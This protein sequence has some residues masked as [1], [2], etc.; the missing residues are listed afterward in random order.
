MQPPPRKK[1]SNLRPI[2]FV[3]GF[4]MVIG[5][6]AIALAPKEWFESEPPPPQV[7][8]LNEDDPH[9]QIATLEQMLADHPDHSPIALM[10][11]NLYFDDQNFERAVFYYRQFLKTDTSAGGYEA[12]LDLA[13]ALYQMNKGDEA[14]KEIQWILDRYPDHADA[15]YNLG[16]IQANMGKL[17]EAKTTWEKLIAKHPDDTLAIFAKQSLPMLSKPAGHP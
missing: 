16:A 6:L 17:S 7:E 15:L 12:R 3:A 14:I 10:L 2:L 13:R 5:V 4:V 8:D 11:G 1:Q 9:S